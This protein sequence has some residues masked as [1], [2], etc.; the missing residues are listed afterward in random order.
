[1]DGRPTFHDNDTAPPNG[2]LIAGLQQGLNMDK[3]AH[4]MLQAHW[5]DDADL[6]DRDT[7]VKI[8]NGIG[9]APKPLL[10]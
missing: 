9:V 10:D 1:M 6:T 4:A 5:R 8:A 7:Q 2:M 3:L